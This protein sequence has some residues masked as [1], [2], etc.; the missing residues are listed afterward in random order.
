MAKRKKD[1]D[2]VRVIIR[3]RPLFKS[4]E[5]KGHKSIVTV[6][7]PRHQITVQNP[8]VWFAVRIPLY[9]SW[10][11]S[12]LYCSLV[13]VYTSPPLRSVSTYQTVPPMLPQWTQLLLLLLLLLLSLL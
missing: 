10:C 1:S 13:P 4:E 3:S 6:D 11:L 5:A 7:K 12:V 2:N 9:K 8:D